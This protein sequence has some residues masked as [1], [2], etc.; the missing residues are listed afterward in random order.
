MKSI[1]IEKQIEIAIN[2]VKNAMIENMNADKAEVQAKDRKRK[3][4]YALQEA[5]ARLRGLQSDMYS[6]SLESINQVD[7]ISTEIPEIV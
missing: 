7:K 3:A 2:D 1:S 5:N 4:H 6:I